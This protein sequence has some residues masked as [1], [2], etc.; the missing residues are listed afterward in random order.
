MLTQSA[1]LVPYVLQRMLRGV[2][3]F[4]QACL[5]L[6]HSTVPKSHA[7]APM[8]ICAPLIQ[9][10]KALASLHQKCSKS[11]QPSVHCFNA[12]IMHSLQ[13]YKNP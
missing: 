2:C 5:S 12:S 11:V 10:A 4:A 8:A 1:I 3:V 9:A 13:G 6:C 7:L